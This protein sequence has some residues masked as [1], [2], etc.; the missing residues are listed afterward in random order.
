M[1]VTFIKCEPVAGNILSVHCGNGELVLIKISGVNMHEQQ[2]ILHH[3]S[4]LS[5]L[6]MFLGH[7][8][9]TGVTQVCVKL[10]ALQIIY[11]TA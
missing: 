5:V 11:F 6:V 9:V 3:F 10:S 8:N 4:I 2:K 7:L 1:N